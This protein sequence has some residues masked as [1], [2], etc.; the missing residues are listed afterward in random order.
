M[1][2]SIPASLFVIRSSEY[3]WYFRLYIVMKKIRFTWF[4]RNFQCGILC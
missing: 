1:K 2:L 3:V 4:Q